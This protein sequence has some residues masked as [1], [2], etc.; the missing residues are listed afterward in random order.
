MNR[1][2][3]RNL[4]EFSVEVAWRAGR[5]ALAHYQVGV[6]AETKPDNSPVTIADR[7]A[8]QIARDLIATRFPGDGIVGEEFGV[9]N[10]QATR[11][12]ILD[13]IDGTRTF[14]R[15]VPFFG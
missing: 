11:R 5:A 7:A 14:V 9:T 8:E 15:G 6:T 1:E 12:W 4:V 2:P 13:P 10:P 3:F